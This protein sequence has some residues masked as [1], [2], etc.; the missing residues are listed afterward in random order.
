MNSARFC[1][2][3]IPNLQGGTLAY[4]VR[5]GGQRIMVF[6]GM[7]YIE[8]ELVGLQ[9]DV[10]LVSAAGSR[11]EIYDYTE[12]PMR[13]L[14]NPP[15]VIPSVGTSSYFLSRPRNRLRLIRYNSSFMRSKQRLLART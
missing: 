3:V 1:V 14:G 15:L 13:V 9:P 8:R 6:G 11:K 12:R 4:L 5:I 2:K 10:A 7:N